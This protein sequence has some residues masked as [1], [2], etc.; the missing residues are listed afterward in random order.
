MARFIKS[1]FK[2]LWGTVFSFFY[3]VFATNIVAEDEEVVTPTPSAG[4]PVEASELEDDDLSL[5]HI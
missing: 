3:G 5:I 2:V 1:K 4:P